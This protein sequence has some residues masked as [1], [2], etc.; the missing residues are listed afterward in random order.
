MGLV[1]FIDNDFC[2]IDM[3]IGVDIVFYRIVEVVDCIVIIVLRLV[4]KS[5]KISLL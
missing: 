4:I 2:G 5:L 3:I 1:G